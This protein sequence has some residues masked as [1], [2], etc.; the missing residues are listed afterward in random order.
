M[1]TRQQAHRARGEHFLRSALP[2]VAEATG[3]VGYADA[4]LSLVVRHRWLATSCLVDFFVD[5]LWKHVPNE[6]VCAR[7]IR[8]GVS[9][10]PA[11]H[12]FACALHQAS[13][14][15]SLTEAQLQR[16]SSGGDPVEM[17]AAG[18]EEGSG[19]VCSRMHPY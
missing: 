3:L 12:G 13:H 7:S 9:T 5:D 8:C 2:P 16:L 14:L 17:C 18:S 10:L 15:E 6:W 11:H 4:L 1:A 19:Q